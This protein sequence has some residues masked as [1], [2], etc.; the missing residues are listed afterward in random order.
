MTVEYELGPEYTLD[1]SKSICR[2]RETGLIV[3]RMTLRRI[4]W[5]WPAGAVSDNLSHTTKMKRR[6][7]IRFA[8]EAD[9]VADGC[10]VRKRGV[11][12]EREEVS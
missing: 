6:C 2:A 3:G 7:V 1:D 8:D 12:A 4:V 10:A 11:D 5:S 9:G